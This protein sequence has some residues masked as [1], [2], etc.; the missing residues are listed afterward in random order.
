MTWILGSLSINYIFRRISIPS[1]Y[2]KI[3]Y[4]KEFEDKNKNY[5]NMDKYVTS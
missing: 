5:Y 4:L 1:K 3:K 2:V